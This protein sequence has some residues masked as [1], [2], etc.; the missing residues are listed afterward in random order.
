MNPPILPPEDDEGV[1]S[2]YA[3]FCGKINL[4]TVAKIATFLNYSATLGITDFHLAMHSDGGVIDD[5]LALYRYFQQC[6]R[7]SMK[8]NL[9]NPA[10]LKSIAAV[11]FFGVPAGNRF[12]GESAIFR[13][14]SLTYWPGGRRARP[15]AA[16]DNHET[17][18]G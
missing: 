1:C 16:K 7:S 11:A 4:E 15:S 3:T 10:A 13:V 8:L 9:Y 17:E 12:A 18:A 14:P 2:R 5:G 6:S